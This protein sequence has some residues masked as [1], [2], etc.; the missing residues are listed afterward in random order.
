MD[1]ITQGGNG[2]V[3]MARSRSAIA[4]DDAV[5]QESNRWSTFPAWPA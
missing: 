5:T 4:T 1:N 3:A 2:E